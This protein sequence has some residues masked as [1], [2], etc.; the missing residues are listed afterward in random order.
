MLS[1]HGAVGLPPPE[2]GS[3]WKEADVAL[4]SAR[5]L[6][7]S[8]SAS[9]VC[10]DMK[11]EDFAEAHAHEAHAHMRTEKCEASNDSDLLER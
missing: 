7:H 1:R 5:A 11:L 10:Y 8:T 3:R 9:A 6:L 2:P 4:T